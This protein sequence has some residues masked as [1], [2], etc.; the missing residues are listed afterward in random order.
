MRLSPKRPENQAGG[1]VSGVG[2]GGTGSSAAMLTRSFVEQEPAIGGGSTGLQLPRQRQNFQ[3]L[4]TFDTRAGF[5]GTGSG[6]VP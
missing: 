3:N 1:F 5:T 4:P 2:G 6:G